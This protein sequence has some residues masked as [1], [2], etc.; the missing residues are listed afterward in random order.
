MVGETVIDLV[1]RDGVS[2]E[3][4]GGSPANVALTLARLGHPVRFVTDLAEDERGARAQQHLAASAVRVEFRPVSRT[5]TA[6]ARLQADGS[7][8]YTVDISFNPRAVE[9]GD[10]THVYTGSIAAFLPP[11]AQVVRALLEGLPAGVTTSLDPNIRPA[12]IAPP[13][14]ARTTFEALAAGVDIIKLSDED[15]NWLYPGDP[16]GAILDRLLSLGAALA[17]VTRGGDGMVLASATARLTIPAARINVADTIG[18][19]DSAMGAI[20]DMVVRRGFDNLNE[21]ALSHIGMWTAQVAGITT[22]R[23]GA[24]PPWR[25]EVT[26]TA[27]IVKVL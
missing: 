8:K 27:P 20:I 24:N 23:P 9:P 26:V 6:E 17:V 2:T 14:T 4:V 25:E 13:E 7:A 5:S 16:V 3:H 12:L 10:A 18:S 15:A 21:A 19:G 22:S 1:E 11:S